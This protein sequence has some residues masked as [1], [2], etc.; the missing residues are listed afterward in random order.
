MGL[1]PG[2][3][4]GQGQRSRDTGTSLMSRN[5]CYTVP[6]D[7]LSIHAF[8]L[9]S[10]VTLSFQYKCQTARCNVYIMEW[11]TPSLTVWFG[12]YPGVWTLHRSAIVDM[13]ACQLSVRLVIST[14]FV[15]GWS[16]YFAEWQL[17]YVEWRA[18]AG[19]STTRWTVLRL[20]WHWT[21]R[22]T[23]SSH[24]TDIFHFVQ[25]ILICRLFT[26]ATLA[27]V[28][29]TATCPSVRPSVRLW[30]AGIVPSRA[31]AGSWSLHPLIAPSL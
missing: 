22:G 26:R 27:R 7:V 12:H 5:V 24:Q 29:A 11:A 13:S 23:S 1:L 4:Q 21:S 15:N 18:A 19:L 31:K 20:P 2:C 17:F 8:T 6:S 30:H 28:F 3:A 14:M 9:R 10:T 25:F 16:S